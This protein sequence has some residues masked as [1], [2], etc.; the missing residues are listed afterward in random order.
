M[1]G[2]NLPTDFA[3]PADASRPRAS[4][5][6]AHAITWKVAWRANCCWL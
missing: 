4:R 6:R 1:K 5:L 3:A 2:T